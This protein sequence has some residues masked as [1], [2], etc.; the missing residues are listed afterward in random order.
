MMSAICKS[1]RVWIQFPHRRAFH[2][3]PPPISLS[4][5]PETI[6]KITNAC[7]STSSP[8]PSTTALIPS[9]PGRSHSNLPQQPQETCNLDRS[10]P[11]SS[12]KQALPIATRT[13]SRPTANM[14]S[15]SIPFIVVA[16][17][18]G[19]H[20]EELLRDPAT[21]LMP[22]ETRLGRTTHRVEDAV[23]CVARQAARVM[24]EAAGKAPH[25]FF[26]AANQ[27]M[28]KRR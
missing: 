22:W 20:N 27:H 25:V 5:A 10:Q 14:S 1:Q 18:T 6:S 8:T 4:L 2:T 12:T 16:D 15:S 26:A 19:K 3:S 9:P 24:F 28:K 11:S 23:R 21:G 13:N 17:T 7:D